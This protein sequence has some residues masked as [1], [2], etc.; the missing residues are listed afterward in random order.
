VALSSDGKKTL[1]ACSVQV[2]LEQQ[3]LLVLSSFSSSNQL[4]SVA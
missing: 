4:G 2:L 3:V 1:A